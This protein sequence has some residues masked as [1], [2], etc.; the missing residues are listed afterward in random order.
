MIMLEQVPSRE[1]MVEQNWLY[2]PLSPLDDMPMGAAGKR[3]SNE[4]LVC[5]GY[6][7]VY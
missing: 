6:V 7:Y 5:A 3:A 1:Q 2:F 4:F